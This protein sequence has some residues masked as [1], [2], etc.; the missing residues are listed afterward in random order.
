MR[1]Q[2]H[3][4]ALL[5]ILGLANRVLVGQEQALAPFPLH[6]ELELDRRECV[7]GEN[8]T[9]VTRVYNPNS[10]TVILRDFTLGYEQPRLEASSADGSFRSIYCGPAETAPG[11]ACQIGPGG[12]VTHRRFAY[13]DLS[14]MRWPDRA[15]VYRL[16]AVAPTTGSGQV[17][18]VTV[19]I[20]WICSEVELR[21]REASAIE[22]SAI[23]FL[24]DRQ[25]QF[26]TGLR[27]GKSVSLLL[28]TTCRTFLSDY[29]N[30]VY[31]PEVRWRLARALVDLLASS[32]RR[33]LPSQTVVELV[34]VLDEAVTYCL[35]MGL[36]YSAE[37]LTWDLDRGGSP[38][39]ELAT[40]HSRV[41]LLQHIANELNH[42]VPDDD[43]A[44]RY[45]RAIVL[46][47]M[48]S[49]HEARQEINALLGQYPAGIY[50]KHAQFLLK[51]IDRRAAQQGSP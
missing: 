33:K 4:L 3:M 36:P 14:V 37:F 26:D 15:G 44:D 18:G 43:D 9:L 7:V 42:K 27:E 51:E 40:K 34:S 6:M 39:F 38:V 17:N 21:V 28:A 24:R 31:A 35:S 5:L 10:Q 29:G 23:D 48:G 13:Q 49:K 30:T 25:E 41:E 46:D 50:A 47:A 2:M 22:R 32:D 16:R 1:P 11:E 20:D 19:K 8:F 12:S 45:R